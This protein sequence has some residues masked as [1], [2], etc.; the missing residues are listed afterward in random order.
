MWEGGFTLVELIIAMTIGGIL[1]AIVTPRLLDSQARSIRAHMV[2]DGKSAQ[3][4]L[5][6]MLDDNPKTGYLGPDGMAPVV[7]GPPYATTTPPTIAFSLDDGTPTGPYLTTLTKGN[8]LTLTV[9]SAIMYSMA[10]THITQGGND[11]TFAEPVTLT[12]TGS[13]V[14]NST[15]TGAQGAT[16]EFLC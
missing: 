3:A 6:S 4:V 7:L 14:W 8:R 16:D 9:P 12:Q 13:C 5:M 11:A 2:S 1:S 10:V 15:A